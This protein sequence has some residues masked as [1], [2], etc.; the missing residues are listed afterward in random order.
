M[1]SL[2]WGTA[3][4]ILNI[5]MLK[6]VNKASF[7]LSSFSKNDLYVFRQSDSTCKGM[8]NLC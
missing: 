7:F 1:D 2:V 5:Q 8:K 4:N 3:I 6:S